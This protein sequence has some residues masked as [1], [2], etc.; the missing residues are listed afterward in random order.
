MQIDDAPIAVVAPSGVYQLDR[1]EQGLTIIH[2]H[3][4]QTRVPDDILAPVRYLAGSD[5]HRAKQ[6]TQALTETPYSAIW[7]ARG[8][9]GITRILS[10]LPWNRFAGRPVIGFS[11]VT[12][13]LNPLWQRTGCV[14]IHGPVV[15]SLP[16]TSEPAIEHLFAL[17]KGEATTP[18]PGAAWIPGESQGPL[19]GGNLCMLASLCG[20]PYQLNANGA[21]VV[22][23]EIAESPYK[24]DRMLEQLIQSGSFEGA[25][26]FA[27]GEFHK[28]S[29]PPGSDWRLADVIMDHLEPLQVPVLGQLPIGHGAD[30]YAFPIGGFGQLTS[31]TLSWRID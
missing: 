17:L 26:G 29:P 30:N 27:I 24:V 1:F 4:L 16:I 22:L 23:E 6:L 21:I 11:D 15:H 7:V 5:A 20:T 25:V 8:G 31:T 19:V 3:G 14:G 2:Q 28:C 12:A 10:M 13:L 9:F 18:M